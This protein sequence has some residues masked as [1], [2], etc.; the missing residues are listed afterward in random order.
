[1]TLKLLTQAVGPWPMNTYLIVCGET[2][3]SVIV[4]PGADAASILALARG[5]R[6]DRILLTHGHPDHCGALAEV[7]A[8]TGAPVYIH[9]ADA[10]MF[11]LTPDFPLA[12]GEALMIGAAAIRVIHTPGHTPGA[13]CFDIGSGR[14]LVGD[15]LFTGGPGATTCPQD[16]AVTMVMMQSIIFTWPDETSFHPGHGPAGRIGAERPA[17]EA[18][19]E[20]GWPADLHGD[21]TW[22]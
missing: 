11:S 1:M 15:A 12:D 20:H 17:Y 5:T 21:V 22:E 13:T 19:F 16:F 7:R 18:F 6:V 3:A 4:D 2:G 10:E 9:P 14:V 8:A